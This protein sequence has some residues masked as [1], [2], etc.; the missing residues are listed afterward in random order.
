VRALNVTATLTND[1]I[2][3]LLAYRL[4]HS[5]QYAESLEIIDPLLREVKRLDDKALLVE[6][7]LVESKVQHA[8]RNLPRA[9]VSINFSPLD[10]EY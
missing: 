2:S 4:L 9:R 7:H 6:I 8:L 1:I 3:Y 10:A 5:K